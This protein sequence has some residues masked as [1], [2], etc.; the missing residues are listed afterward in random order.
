VSLCLCGELLGFFAAESATLKP[1]LFRLADRFMSPD[2]FDPRPTAA[3]A[4]FLRCPLPR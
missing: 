2:N 1:T 3:V 4:S